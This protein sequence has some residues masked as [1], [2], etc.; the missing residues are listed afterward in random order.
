M[1]ATPF[2][3]AL[4]VLVARTSKPLSSE[5]AKIVFKAGVL[6]SNLDWTDG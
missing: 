4:I 2:R 3:V 1:R 5:W 6:A